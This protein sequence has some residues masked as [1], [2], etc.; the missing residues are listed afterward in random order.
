MRPVAGTFSLSKVSFFLP[1]LPSFLK[2]QNSTRCQRPVPSSCCIVVRVSPIF[3]LYDWRCGIVDRLF[4]Y[5]FYII[6]RSIVCF[7]VFL[8]FCF[9]SLPKVWRVYVCGMGF[10]V[11]LLLV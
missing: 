3:N 6:G 5:V 1:F 11:L 4:S 10:F 7:A 9:S 2:K 8:V